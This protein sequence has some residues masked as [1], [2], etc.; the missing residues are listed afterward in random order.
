[1]TGSEQADCACDTACASRIAQLN[2]ELRKELRGGIIV[3]TR[4]VRLLP[5]FEP[6]KLMALL[7]KYDA[8]DGDN[9][10]YGERDFGDVDMDGQSMLWKI[11]YYDSDMLYGS[12]D[13]ADPAVTQRVLTVMLPEE[14]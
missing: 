1:M 5:G 4:G 6:C 11:D 3:A 12:P 9:N 8:F 13:P 2:D 10:P 7:A 14:W